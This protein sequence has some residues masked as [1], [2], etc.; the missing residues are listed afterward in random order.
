MVVYDFYDKIPIISKDI[1][2]KV[3]IAARDLD[4]EL[5]KFE[6]VSLDW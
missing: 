1:L 4:K 3:R 6:A 2:S 5:D